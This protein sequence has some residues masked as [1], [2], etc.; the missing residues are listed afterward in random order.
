MAYTPPAGDS[1]VFAFSAAYTPPAGDAILF[2]SSQAEPESQAFTP[3]F[4]IPWGQLPAKDASTRGGWKQAKFLARSCRVVFG[5]GRKLSADIR[6]NWGRP[7]PSDRGVGSSWN[8]CSEKQAVR[9]AVPWCN[10]RGKDRDRVLLSTDLHASTDR[11]IDLVYANPPRRHL[12]IALALERAENR[13]RKVFDMPWGNPPPKDRRHDT[14]WGRQQYEEIC[15]RKYEPPAGGAIA[16]NLETPLSQV[17]DG[18]HISFYFDQYTYDRRCSQREPSGWRDAYYYTKPTPIPAG[19]SRRYYF[20]LN[21]ALLTRLPERT[22]IDVASITVAT[23]VDSFCWSLSATLN[24][25]A[26]LDLVR[27]GAPVDVEVSINGHLWN[28][29]VEKWS[30]GI[31]FAGGSRSVTG[32][33]PSAAL[34]APFGPVITRAESNARTAVQLAEAALDDVT[35]WTVDWGL[36]DWL[37][38]GGLWSCDGQTPIQVIQEIARAAHG[39]VQT[40]QASQTI[41]IKPRYAVMPWLWGSATPDLIIPESMLLSMDGSWEPRTQYNAAFVSGTGTGGISAKVVRS[42]TAGDV[43][44]PMFTHALITDTDAALAKGRGLL[45]ESG[46]WELQRIVLPLFTDPTVPGLVLPGALLQMTRS[47]GSSWMGQVIG[48]GVTASRTRGGVVVRQT[49]DVERYRGD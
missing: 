3:D 33:S 48:T 1:L 28:L 9:T 25:T 38:P 45:A 43:A 19:A 16:F 41:L 10:L 2:G 12:G 7:Q 23:D 8:Q 29:Q 24:S 40:D 5:H 11:P 46:S 14:V 42:G 21:Q 6:G 36:V 39:F 35:G 4:A 13:D 17:G 30:E 27:P 44:P 37:V 49:L 22:P 31:Q 18:D 26:A 34:A 20:V 15:W 47:S 32:R